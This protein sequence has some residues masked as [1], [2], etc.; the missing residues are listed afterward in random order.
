M[1]LLDDAKPRP[2]GRVLTVIIR[3]D[4]PMVLCEDSPSYRSV[5]ITLTDEQVA[6]LQLHATGQSGPT[7]YRE[8]VSRC[9]L[10]PE[11]TDEE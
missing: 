8:S 6:A 1:S 2:A 10:E 3:N 9:I 7:V 4:A 11:I 5:R